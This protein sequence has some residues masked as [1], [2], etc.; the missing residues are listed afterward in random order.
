MR[1]KILNT[2]T[3]LLVLVSSPTDLFSQADYR[4]RQVVNYKHDAANL[5]EAFADEVE[6]ERIGRLDGSGEISG[7][8]V[9]LSS[10][11]V[12]R[13]AWT[14][15]FICTQFAPHPR[16]HS[17]FLINNEIQAVLLEIFNNSSINK[18][19]AFSRQLQR[20][21]LHYKLQLLLRRQKELEKF[22]SISRMGQ[23]PSQTNRKMSTN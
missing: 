7:S 23:H 1:I 3:Y 19:R 10:L 6:K 2:V 17:V 21:C 11:T 8:G 20:I 22:C 5:H 16:I 18:Q 9:P 14:S 4:Y 12:R 15:L 13:A